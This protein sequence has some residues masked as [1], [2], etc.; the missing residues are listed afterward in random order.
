MKIA[1]IIAEY[2]PFHNGHAYHLAQ[3]RAAGAD[4][5]AVV[6]SGN[7]V[8]RGGPAL[9]DKWTRAKMAMEAGAD[10]V[11][12]LP[13]YWAMAPAERFA[14]GAARILAAL[15]INL[16]SFGCESGSA[17]PL[18]EAAESMR[19]EAFQSRLKAALSKGISYPRAVSEAAGKYSPLLQTPNNAL[20]IEYILAFSRLNWPVE[21]LGV[22]RS[23]P[24]DS[25]QTAE[26]IASAS[27]LRFL[28]ENS[29]AESV[30]EFMPPYAWRLLKEAVDKGTA[31]ASPARLERALLA[32]LRTMTPADFI[33]LPDVSEGLE[34]RLVK[35][36]SAPS[37]EEFYSLAK[38]KRVIH[39]RL[40]RIAWSALLGVYKDQLPP[41]P[42]YIKP[43]ALNEKGAQLLNHAAHHRLS[44]PV[45]AKPA[46]I[47]KTGEAAQVFKLE[48]RATDCFSLA[49]PSVLPGGL[50]FL[51]SPLFFPSAP[52]F[53]QQ[54]SE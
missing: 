40:R 3:T 47:P 1:G 17:L 12:E 49:L 30:T 43:L 36:A 25:N 6:M 23:V 18:A 20:A 10:L 33:R 38:S 42:P 13:V 53:L 8:Q 15:G 28:I 54:Y 16:L 26:G 44:L 46:A 5:V 2:N 9:C 50:E 35:A 45:Y 11:V 19:S 21:L 22:S 39:A 32:A 14:M 52:S 7:F 34:N 4:L 24:H 51:R 31:P 27:H 37:M 41:L 48:C 29:G